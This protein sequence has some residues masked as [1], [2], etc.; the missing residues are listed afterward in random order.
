MRRL[1]VLRERDL[2]LGRSLDLRSLT[3]REKVLVEVQHW[4]LMYDRVGM[5]VWMS[6]LAVFY[7]SC[8]ATG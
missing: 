2:V 1:G 3:M 5:L 4:S 6:K 8:E 7:Y